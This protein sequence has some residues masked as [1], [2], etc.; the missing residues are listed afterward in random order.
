M[1]DWLS[2]WE[3]DG[4]SDP[5][6]LVEWME[7]RAAAAADRL[8][9]Q[10]TAEI[11]VALNRFADSL[12]DDTIIASGDYAA[13]DGLFQVWM[14]TADDTLLPLMR[15]AYEEG[16]GQAANGAVSRA[17]IS[18][19]IGVMYDQQIPISAQAY[20]GSRQNMMKG[21]GQTLFNQITGKV[22]SMVQAGMSTADIRREIQALGNFS[23]WRADAIARTE[24]LMALDAGH[25]EGD[26]L[27]GEFGPKEKAWDSTLDQRTRTSHRN[28][29]RNTL[30]PYNESFTVG[31]ASMM[32]PR[33]PMGPAAQVINCRCV[34]QRYYAGD[35][36][37]DGTV[38]E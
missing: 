25:L 9:E 31:G 4:P 6:E 36:R 18:T 23:I 27:L 34:M 17:T 33:D 30:I 32:T 21:V 28:M 35:K 7:T 13:F 1:A 20:L 24:T 11:R 2:R 15:A 37:P 29:N 5:R 12:P 19:E 10:L 3:A 38:I 8:A 22:A 16:A 14:Q 26:L